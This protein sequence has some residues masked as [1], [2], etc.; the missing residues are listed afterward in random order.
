MCNPFVRSTYVLHQCDN[1]LCVA[2]GLLVICIIQSIVSITDTKL[3]NIFIL[4]G[5]SLC[6]YTS[7]V[8]WNTKI[9]NKLLA[10]IRCC[11]SPSSTSFKFTD[12][13]CQINYWNNFDEL[14]IGIW[15]FILKLHMFST[16]AMMQKGKNL[17]KQILFQR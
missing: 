15:M 12:I 4:M 1:Y 13:L 8:S 6:C 10:K 17:N 11:S 9:N 2:T 5:S 16:N 14:L 7:D 3:A